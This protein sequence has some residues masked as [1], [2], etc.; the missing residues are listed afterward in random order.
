MDQSLFMQ[1]MKKIADDKDS[2][3][4]LPQR[5]QLPEAAIDD[6]LCR[7]RKMNERHEFSPGQIVRMKPGVGGYNFGDVVAHVVVTVEIAEVKAMNGKRKHRAADAQIEVVDMVVA[8]VR[9]D[10]NYLIEYAVD[11]RRF[12]PWPEQQEE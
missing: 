3:I 8:H 5:P 11:S 4:V 10:H 7:Y 2:E 12:E 1:L 6:L 9:Y